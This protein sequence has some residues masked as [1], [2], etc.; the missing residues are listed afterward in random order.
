MKN[1][2]YVLKRDGRSELLNYEKINKVLEWSTE[3]ITGVNASDVAM[4][5][6]LQIYNGINTFDIHRVLIQSAADMITEDTP[7]YQYVASKLLNYLLR[8]EVF[9]TYTNFPRFKDFIK[10]NIE[11]DV[12][13]GDIVNWY[14]EK[15][16]DKIEGFI[17]HKRDEELTYAGI[18]QL[19]DKYLVQNRKTGEQHETPQ[20]MYMMISITLFAKYVGEDRM[21][22]VKRFY[23]L[24]SLQKISLPTPI[25][26]GVRTPNRQFSSCVLIDVAD[27]LDSIGSSNQAVLRYI[28][29]RAGIGLNFRLRAI[30]SEVNGGEKIHTGIVPFLK[31][32]ESSVKS[33]SQGGIRGGAATAHYPF[34]HKEIMDIL[35]LKN[36]TGNDLNRV[37][38]MDHSIQLCRL[39][40]KRFVS[41]ENLALFSPSDVPELYDAF[42]YDNDLFEKLYTKYESDDSINKIVIPA[43][44]VMNLLLQERLENGRIYIQNI[45]NTNTHSGFIDKINMSNLCQEITLPQSPIYDI[46]DGYFFKKLVKVKNE[47]LDKF[48]SLLNNGSIFI[49]PKKSRQELV[50]KNEIGNYFEF[51]DSK[52]ENDS[53]YT[54]INADFE[55]VW[56]E[57]QSEISLCVLGAINLGTIKSLDE[58]EEICEYTV[59]MLDYI[60]EI[61][62]YPVEAARKMLKRRSLGVGV[63]NFAYWL[64]K[65]GLDYSKESLVEIDRL[66]EHVQYYLLKASNNLAKEYGSCEYFHRTKYSLGMLPIDHYSKSV[67]NLV[68]RDLD[69][70]WEGLRLDIEKWGL[71][72]SVV[73]AQMPTESSSVVSSSTNG[74]E[75]PRKLISVKKSKSGSPLPVV[76]PEI[77]KLKNKYSFSWG[78]S[79]DDMNNVVSVIQKYFDQGISVNHYY[80]KKKYADGNIPL[81]EVAKD[82]LTFYKHGGKQIYYANSKDYKSDR[83]EDMITTEKIELIEVAGDNDCGDACTI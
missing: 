62:D 41:K 31:V 70:D 23:E 5:A 44:D 69:C 33:C 38:R 2:I 6:K 24:L 4:N 46:N 72:N 18:Q 71:R 82:L 63:T 51:V 20:F 22:K 25:L 15:E 35:V 36:N 64:A 32:F 8:K 27:D 65:N 42:G 12:Y 57:K 47:N 53:E 55:Y 54:Y 59:R 14:T 49:D 17:K 60:I 29:N 74:I 81:S 34:W 75:A 30:G 76:V 77:S 78:F 48:K 3:G 73:S 61:Q 28:S 67:D 66:F 50:Y 58:L 37:R 52:N 56:G 26:A 83:L 1:D 7:N 21:E 13:D 40:Y 19:I 10:N 9:N 79:N 39:F 68:K 16:F 11:R 45:D 80:D 43:V